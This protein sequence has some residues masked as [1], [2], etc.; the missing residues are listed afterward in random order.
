MMDVRMIAGMMMVVF[1]LLQAPADNGSKI[2][3]Y[4]LEYD[5]VNQTHSV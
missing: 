3:S 2:T 4:L 1:G 5:Q